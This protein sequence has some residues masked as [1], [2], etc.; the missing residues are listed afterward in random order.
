MAEQKQELELERQELEIEKMR[1]EQ[2]RLRKLQERLRKEHELRVL[3]LEEN[4]KRLAEATLA[5]LELRDD[6]SVLN[7]DFHDTLSRLSATSHRAE[8]QRIH[9]WINNSPNVAEK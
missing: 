2:E 9:E 8:T 6:L 7:V 5:E 1:E 4:I 3:E